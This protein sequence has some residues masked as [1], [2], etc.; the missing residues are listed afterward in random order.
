M[1]FVFDENF[2]KRLAEGL[3]LLEKS[4]P[5]AIIKV[6]VRSAESLMGRR[7]ATDFELIEA[8]G[9]DGVLITRDKDFKDIKI[10]KAI[11]E[12][13][14]TKVLFVKSAKKMILFWDILKS[15][16]NRWDE[17]KEKLSGDA[18]PYVYEYDIH[19]GVKECHFSGSK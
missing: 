9:H 6:D 18:P 11:I 16:I 13:S 19:K 7:G 4:N 1:F 3:D 17:V 15:I 14:G 2:S 10:Y 5:A 12:K 8:I